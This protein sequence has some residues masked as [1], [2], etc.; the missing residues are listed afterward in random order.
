MSS[1]SKLTFT[2]VF[3][4]ICQKVDI[5]PSIAPFVKYCSAR[6]SCD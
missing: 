1:W 3:A 6:I 4:N 2:D 5:I